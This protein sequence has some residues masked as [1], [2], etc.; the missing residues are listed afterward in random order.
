MCWET[1]AFLS[2]ICDAF[3]TKSSRSFMFFFSSLMVSTVP[4]LLR[5]A[6][7][8]SSLLISFS[9][10][11]I[12]ALRA[13]PFSSAPS[14]SDSISGARA[15]SADFFSASSSILFIVVLLYR[16][17]IVEHC[18]FLRIALLQLLRCLVGLR[19]VLSFV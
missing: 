18:I 7:F 3:C 16:F 4:M 5:T 8:C 9:R 13:T 17:D 11:S 15:A 6:A 10:F 1:P 12:S 2:V 19:F 14:A